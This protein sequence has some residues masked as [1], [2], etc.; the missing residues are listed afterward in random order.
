M[1]SL[2]IDW[3]FEM[4]PLSFD[5]SHTKQANVIFQNNKLLPLNLSV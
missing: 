1:D 3:I 2:L 5:H 4:V